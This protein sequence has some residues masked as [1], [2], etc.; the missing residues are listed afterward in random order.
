[1]KRLINLGFL[2]LVAAL[3]TG[4]LAGKYMCNYA[5]KYEPHGVADLTHGG[6]IA[7]L[8]DFLFDKGE[9]PLLR[10]AARAF[11]RRHF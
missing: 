3:S 2:V 4:C 10:I 5:L 1:M 8:R 6:G 7:L 11:F 9:D